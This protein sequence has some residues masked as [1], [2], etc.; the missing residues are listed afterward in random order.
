MEGLAG[1]NMW[2]RY[3][4]STKPLPPTMSPAKL[5]TPHTARKG[6]PNRSKRLL[7]SV[8]QLGAGTVTIVP[9]R[10]LTVQSTPITGVAIDGDKPGTTSYSVTCT[11]GQ[12]A[13]LSAP[14][15]WVVGDR[16]YEFDRWTV[17]GSTQSGGD[18]PSS[19]CIAMDGDHTATAI[20]RLVP[21]QL[22]IE[23]PDQRLEKPLLAGEGTMRVDLYAR[24]LVGFGAIQAILSFYGPQGATAGSFTIGSDAQNTTFG[25]QAVFWN[26]DLFPSIFPV[27]VDAPSAPHYREAFGFV[28]LND[29]ID[30]PEKTWL[31]SVS[32][33][34][35]VSPRDEGT[36]TIAA[37]S[38][39]T[40]LAGAGGTIPFDV[41]AGSATFARWPIPGDANRDCKVDVLDLL[42]IRGRLGQDPGSGDNWKADVNNDGKINLLDLMFV[43][44]RLFDECGGPAEPRDCGVS[45]LLTDVSV[46]RGSTA[47]TI[48]PLGLGE[49]PPDRV[50]VSVNGVVK[51]A[52]FPLGTA[53]IPVALDPGKNCLRIEAIS[54]S[55][56]ASADVLVVIGYTSAGEQ[57]QEASI[58]VGGSAACTITK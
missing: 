47:I 53:S 56:N 14:L 22:I 1:F 50:T 30:L 55:S 52:Q 27:Y 16:V 20:Y 43:R 5:T 49:S 26:T 58:P 10:T 24:G 18:S 2:Y 40:T 38:L 32:Y 29:D 51:L 21:R 57:V 34:Y 45:K 3:T 4:P 54:G 6:A 28:S 44:S 12:Q 7:P 13:C 48:G 39:H 19:V 8:R 37:N 41:I 33:D 9:R 35:S 36:F 17:D 46:D 11:D 25:G 23:G 42:A 31:M 15:R